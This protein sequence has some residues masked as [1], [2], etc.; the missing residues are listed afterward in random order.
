MSFLSVLKRVAL[1]RNSVA[2]FSNVYSQRHNSKLVD[3][4]SKPMKFTTVYYLILS[5]KYILAI[6]FVIG[7]ASFYVNKSKKKRRLE[8]CTYLKGDPNFKVTNFR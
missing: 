6:T 4:V 5:S 8:G 3:R 2:I 7:I 1:R